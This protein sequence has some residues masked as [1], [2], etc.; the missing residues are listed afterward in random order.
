[1]QL[2]HRH[3]TSHHS[4]QLPI[5]LFP[6]AVIRAR[7][8]WPWVGYSTN[9]APWGSWKSRTCN[10]GTIWL[11]DLRKKLQHIPGTDPWNIMHKLLVEEGCGMFHGYTRCFFKLISYHYKEDS[12]GK[13]GTG[14][15]ST[16]GS[17][18][19][20]Q[21]MRMYDW[22]VLQLWTDL[23]FDWT[24]IFYVPYRDNTFYTLFSRAED[25]SAPSVANKSLRP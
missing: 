11:Q 15:I 13:V 7:E 9:F 3:W 1:M 19:H 6:Q 23:V 22:I 5:A 4:L 20:V 8:N 25:G 16:L 2:A 14:P 18:S 24:R 21:G 12:W 17:S 10:F